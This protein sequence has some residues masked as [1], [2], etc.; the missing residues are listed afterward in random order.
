MFKYILVILFFW[1]SSCKEKWDPDKQFFRQN[2]EIRTK[3][4]LFEY[5]LEQNTFNRLREY[6][7]TLLYRINTETPLYKLDDLIG[8][9]YSI[10]ALNDETG[11][12]WE[13]RLYLWQDIIE[14]KWGKTSLEYKLCQKAK[15]FVIITCND[16][17]IV[18]VEFL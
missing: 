1:V 3:K 9:T 18:E 11:T 16:Q 4:E 12:R 6:E 5:N 7:V 14:N 8:N 10:L 15:E 17:S 13:R 2:E